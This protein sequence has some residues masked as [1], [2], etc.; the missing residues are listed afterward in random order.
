MKKKLF[1]MKWCLFYFYLTFVYN[2]YVPTYHR[3]LRQRLFLN[4][5]T[6]SN[7]AGNRHKQNSWFCKEIRE[8]NFRFWWRRVHEDASQG[9]YMTEI[10][11]FHFY[12]SNIAKSEN[13]MLWRML[14]RLE[15]C[16]VYCC[17]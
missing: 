11:F 2:C 5:K 13:A 16:I 8:D 10:D 12:C 1:W 14:S 17:I 9:M 7:T 3:F 4:I 15:T 6:S